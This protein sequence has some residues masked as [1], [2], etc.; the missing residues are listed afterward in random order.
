[1]PDLCE[2]WGEAQQASKTMTDRSQSVLTLTDSAT[3]EIRSIIDD[4]AVPEGAGLRI[5]SDPA[6]GGLTLT[7]ATEP[8]AHDAVLDEN[9]ARVFLDSQAAALLDTKSLDAATD[10]DGQLHFTVT[11]APV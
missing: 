4:A 2:P 5:A 6:A 11:D 8:G 1:M 10:P 7:L 9:G 3:T